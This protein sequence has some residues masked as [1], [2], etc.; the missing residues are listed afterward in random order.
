[1][2]VTRVPWLP[3]VVCLLLAAA[4]S[5][6]VAQ[7][8][9]STSASA[10]SA[11]VVLDP[12]PTDWAA[13]E[14]LAA[15]SDTVKWVLKI[16]PTV[17]GHAMAYD[18]ARGRVVL[19]G[20]GAISGSSYADTWDWDGNTWVKRTPATSPPARSFHAMAYDSARGHLVLFG[21]VSGYDINDGDLPHDLADTWESDGNTW[22]Q[23][24]PSTSPP[25]RHGHA[26]AY[27]SA[28]GRVVLFGGYYED[29]D[30]QYQYFA[31]TWEWDGNTW[32]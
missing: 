30:F 7:A 9:A 29:E 12:A 10:P 26:M 20:G 16:P 22:V 1:M 21:G 18:S 5:A 24:T 4:P 25:A 27:D 14:E 32:V 31:D 19:S 6:V 15:A 28:R 2:A 8:P 13:P 17:Y 3:V 23:R 11:V